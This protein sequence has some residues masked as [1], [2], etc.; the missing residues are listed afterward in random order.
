MRLG[1]GAGR[2]TGQSV[3]LPVFRAACSD[4]RSSTVIASATGSIVT[5]LADS[6]AL[7]RRL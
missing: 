2:S 1:D 5:Q 6:P 4:S 7:D 3:S